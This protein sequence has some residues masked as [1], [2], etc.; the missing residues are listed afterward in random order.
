MNTKSWGM[1]TATCVALLLTAPAL[2]QVVRETGTNSI[3]G[4]LDSFNPADS[5]GF[6]SRGNEILFADVDSEIYQV[7]GRRGGDHDDDGGC[8]SHTAVVSQNDENGGCGDDGGGPGGLCLQ[9]FD[10]AANMI[11]WAD[12]P[13]RP[14][15]QR[16][17]ALACPLPFTQSSTSYQLRVSL[18][19]GGC[20]P[21]GGG[22]ESLSSA[23]SPEAPGTPYIVNWSLRRVATDGSL[24]SQSNR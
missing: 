15:W 3:A 4:L 22:H 10:S 13:A 17:P 7:Q 8:G 18:K 9:V 2:G 12:R 21:G 14:G 1:M 24:V 23:A 11:C 6:S 16:D 20:G 5:F 19:E